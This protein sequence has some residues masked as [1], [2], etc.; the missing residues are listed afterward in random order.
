[1]VDKNRQATGPGMILLL[2]SLLVG[3]LFVAYTLPPG[4]SGGGAEGVSGMAL[5]CPASLTRGEAGTV[6]V[7][8]EGEADG[9]VE[10]GVEVS[11]INYLVSY[12][13]RGRRICSERVQVLPGQVAEV[14][15]RVEAADVQG[16]T[17]V[18][19]KVALPGDGGD[20]FYTGFCGSPSWN[21]ERRAS[22][23][24]SV[25]GIVLS[26]LGMAGG[27]GLWLA[28]SRRRRGSGGGEPGG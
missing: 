22:L 3:L 10:Y 7:T 19:V 14:R 9:A 20:E 2:F 21:P 15:C 23:P 1:M 12:V 8:I 11:A 26:L 28:G 4:L 27:V 25:A 24:I 6:V 17:Y 16:A 13:A 5:D 18:Q